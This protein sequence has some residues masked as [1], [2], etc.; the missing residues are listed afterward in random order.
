MELV[1]AAVDWMISFA[2]SPYALAALFVFAFWESS[3]FPLPPDPLLIAMAVGKPESALWYAA[4]CTV[5]SVLGA[6]LGYLIGLKG[7]RPIAERL[8]KQERLDAA[9]GLYRRYDAWAVIAAAMTPVPF[10][11][12]TIT[13][14]L[15]RVNF[16]RFV[17]AS[18]I[19]RGLR[20][21]AIGAAV[22]FFGPT[23]QRVLDQYFELLT[24]GF[25]ALI[26]LGFVAVRY[27]GAYLHR[28]NQDTESGKKG[29]LLG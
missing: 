7:G 24:I 8:F 3:F 1:H 11:V 27:G 9:S 10:K 28:R 19:G 14:G 6:M 13:A 15:A 20:F 2:G 22:F 12:F 23:I 16:K 29:K 17:V 5:G 18:V 25:L 26:I 4:I 21:F